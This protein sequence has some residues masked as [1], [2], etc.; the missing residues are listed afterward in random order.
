MSNGSTVC[1]IGNG[2][3]DFSSLPD[4]QFEVVPKETARDQ[5]VRVCVGAVLGDTVTN[6]LIRIVPARLDLGQESLSGSHLRLPASRRRK[7]SL[8]LRK[9]LQG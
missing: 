2:G 9:L 4:E 1:S 7:A 3:T 8:L 6:V 5:Q